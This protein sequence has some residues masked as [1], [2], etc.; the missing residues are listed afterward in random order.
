MLPRLVRISPDGNHMATLFIGS[1]SKTPVCIWN[2][3][4]ELVQNFYRGIVKLH[5]T[6][7]R[8]ICFHPS[9]EILATASRSRVILWDFQGTILQVFEYQPSVKFVRFSPNGKLIATISGDGVVRLTDLQGKLLQVFENQNQIRNVCFSSHEQIIATISVDGV[10]RLW[11][12]FGKLISEMRYKPCTN[13]RI[14]FNSNGHNLAVAAA[15]ELYLS[16]IS[17]LQE[18][19]ALGYDWLHRY[20][21]HHSDSSDV[22]RAMC[23]LPPR[24]PSLES[25]QESSE[26]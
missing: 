15:N 20:L 25:N 7:F 26:F 9:E 10:V 6:H 17:N 2:F 21:N 22:D 1:V 16:P 11:N 3:Q 18:L 19:L 12:F 5:A 4:G 13:K 23:E 8:D 14:Q 24:D